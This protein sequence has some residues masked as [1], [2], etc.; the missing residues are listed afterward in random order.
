MKKT[1]FCVLTFCLLFIKYSIAQTNFFDVN[2]IQ[3]IEITFAQPSWDYDLDTA[4]AGADNYIL[5]SSVKINNVLF[6]SV[7]VKYKGNSTYNATYSKN[8]LH[9]ALDEFKNQNY[10]GIKDIKL[11][12][13]Y[14]DPSQIR[15]VLLYNILQN[16]M[17]CPKANFA[18]VYINGSYVGVYSN[19]ENIGKKFLA[20]HFYSNDNT[21]IK[22]NPTVTSGPTNKSNLRFI[23]LADTTGYYNFYDLKSDYSWNDIKNLCD[24]VTNN[25]ANIG[26]TVDMDRV[27]WML[28]FNNVTVNLDSYNGALC[29]NYYMYKDNTNH[30]NPIIWDLNMGF[31]GFPHM[32]SGLSSLAT[33]TVA[34]MQQMLLTAHANDIYW[35]LIKAV[36]NNATYK[37]RYAA[38][39]KTIVDE[40]FSN[41]LFLQKSM[42]L[43][44]IADT[45]IASDTNSFFTYLQFQNS[46]TTNYVSGTN[47]IPG[48]DNLMTAR[49]TYLQSTTEFAAQQPSISNIALSNTNAP[50]NSTIFIT[51]NVTNAA[52][53]MFAY[54]NN[55]VNKFTK[56]QMYDDGLHSDGAANDNVFGIYIQL[57]TLNTQY[58]L[59]AE[60]ANAAIFSPQRAEHEFYNIN[61]TQQNIANGAIVFNEIVANNASGNTNENGLFEDWIELYNNTDSVINLYGLYL[62]D[63]L[64]MPTKYTFANNAIILPHGFLT[65][66]ADEN[67]STNTFFHTN[68]KLAASGETLML[69]NGNGQII[70]SIT[71]NNAAA[72]TSFGRCPNGMGAFEI[73]PTPTFNV[74]NCI[75]VIAENS[76]LNFHI[77]LAPNPCNKQFTITTITDK[78]KLLQI[79][80]SI[81]QIVFSSTIAKSQFIDIETLKSGVYTVVCNDAYSKLVVIK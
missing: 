14:A 40:F 74:S 46:L 48:I 3:K 26:N 59:Y 55:V 53:I 15:E 32:G 69:S 70:D 1:T 27:I 58:Y 38:H 22:C 41:G 37:K 54:R 12:N 29:Q 34:N 73:I 13:G 39:C 71:Y 23:P 11:S 51:A 78:N 49:A 61:T 36:M 68:F 30:Y 76:K 42:Q 9:I 63:S 80:N 47:T 77:I 24:T 20:E 50:L 75:D 72:N 67:N 52:T 10:L 5:A 57:N 35:P 43:M 62:T 66:W 25:A 60:N 16:Y 45:A 21:F 81:G 6:D 8:P 56:T 33:L 44:A 28:A 17:H 7:G 64:Q 2:T 18:Q 65:L 79:I 4:K 31:G 19:A